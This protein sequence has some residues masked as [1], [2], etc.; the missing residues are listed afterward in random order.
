MATKFSPGAYWLFF[1]DKCVGFGRYGR[2]ALTQY[3]MRYLLCNSALLAQETLFLIKKHYFAQN[4]PKVR[5]S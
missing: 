2:F 4:L 3:D 1:H 5:K